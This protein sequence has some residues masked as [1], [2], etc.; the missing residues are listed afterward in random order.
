MDDRLGIALAEERL[1][2]FGGRTHLEGGPHVHLE[3]PIRRGDRDEYSQRLLL[4][5]RP[6]R[7]DGSDDRPSGSGSTPCS[8]VS[9][10]P[11][12][13]RRRPQAAGDAPTRSA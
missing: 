11:E 3:V 1:K 9:A 12:P 6:E 5:H 13:A 10:R 2:Q 4:E 7:T 8:V